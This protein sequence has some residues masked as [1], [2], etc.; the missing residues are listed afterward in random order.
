MSR[1]SWP[2]IAML[3]VIALATV[4][5]ASASAAKT[6]ELLPGKGAIKG[7]SGVAFVLTVGG[8]EIQCKT[9]KFIPVPSTLRP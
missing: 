3:S 8:T 1:F 7:T 9:D 4:A 2:V 5:A 6:V